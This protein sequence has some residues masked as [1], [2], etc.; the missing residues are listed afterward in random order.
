MAKSDCIGDR[1]KT[2]KY[3]KFFKEL[4]EFKKERAIQKRQMMVGDGNIENEETIKRYSKF[5][6]ELDEFKKEQVKNKKEPKKKEQE[7]RKGK[8]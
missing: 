5:F 1:D 6:K 3:S 7:N 2:G 4:D 8:R